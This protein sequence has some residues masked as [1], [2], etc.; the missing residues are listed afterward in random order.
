MISPANL[1]S[2]LPL[3]FP[4]KSRIQESL[5]SAAENK[6]GRRGYHLQRH[7]YNDLVYSLFCYLSIRKIKKVLVYYK[8][9]I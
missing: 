3:V 1:L 9:I 7:C 6:K 2:K 4:E 5:I 8:K